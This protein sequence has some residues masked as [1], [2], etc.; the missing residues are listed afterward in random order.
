MLNYFHYDYPQPKGDA[1][2]SVNI[3]TA[4]CPWEREHR[5]VRIGLKGRDEGGYR[6]EFLQ[7][8][9]KARELQ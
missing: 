7:L 9:D 3:E 6:A 4:A 2:F 8:L 5:L 1:P